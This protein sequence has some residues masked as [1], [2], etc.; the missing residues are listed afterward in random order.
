MSL[1]GWAY[2]RAYIS[3]PKDEPKNLWVGPKM[4]PVVCPSKKGLG[5]SLARALVPGSKWALSPK[6]FGDPGWY[7]TRGVLI[8]T[9]FHRCSFI[10][11]KRTLY[12]ELETS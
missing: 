12:E 5:S 6:L 2:R 9:S 10:S 7:N 4:K 8:G 1:S 11:N 3:G